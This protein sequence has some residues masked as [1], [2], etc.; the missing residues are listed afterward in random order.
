MPDLRQFFLHMDNETT[1]PELI[2]A[3]TPILL[4][5][6][7]N[8]VASSR[9]AQ[10]AFDFE[11]E[12]VRLDENFSVLKLYNGPTGTFKDFG[13]AFLAALM[14][15]LLKD[16]GVA[17]LVSAT[18]GESGVCITEAFKNRRGIKSVMLY[19]AGKIWGLDPAN[20]GGNVIPI[21]VEAT[22]DSCQRLVMDLIRDEGFSRR[23]NVTSANAI[24]IGRL[25]PQS[26]YYLYA[27]ICLKKQLSGDLLFSVPCG[28]F[29][30]LIAGLYA[31]KFGMPV[32]GF[33]A[34]M[35]SN[36]AFGDFFMGKGFEPHTL[37]HTN[38]PALDV[39]IPS[40]YERLLSFYAE[41][42]S[43]MRNMVY[44]ASIDNKTTVNTMKSVWKRYN[45]LLDPPSAVA[46]AAAERFVESSECGSHVVV[47][48]TGHP[49]RSALQ[50]GEIIG[51]DIAVPQRLAALKKRSDPVAVIK[52]DLEALEGA[53][54]SCI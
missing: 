22:F 18:R 27:F 17:T 2:S 43:V 54:A 33:I 14:E 49:A 9:I 53:I 28:N 29:G 13:V 41:A 4:S 16:E 6:E 46:F 35:N 48:A 42:P 34:A 19:P 40:N 30:N 10:S 8:P 37:I 20:N 44:P 38:S 25:L 36:D 45:L 24:N 15:E 31:W 21:Q 39:T 1:Y 23:Y 7:L 3:I 5:G 32:N 52:N 51:Q 50:V 12:L 26:F 11:P 47:L